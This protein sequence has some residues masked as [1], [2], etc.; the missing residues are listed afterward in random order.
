MTFKGFYQQL[1]TEKLIDSF[2]KFNFES[3]LCIGIILQGFK[4]FRNIP[5]KSY[6]LKNQL[7]R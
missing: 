5:A 2:E 7:I 4:I 6:R 1:M 3:F